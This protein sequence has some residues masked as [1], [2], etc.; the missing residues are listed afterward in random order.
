MSVH[1]VFG[2]PGSGK[3]LLGT[4]QMVLRDL[5]ETRKNVGTNFPIDIGK[6]NAYL[7]KRYPDRDFRVCDR[8]FLIDDDNLRDFFKYRGPANPDDTGVIYH[9]DEA[10]IPF[11]AL[12]WAKQNKSGEREV[13]HYLTQHRKMGDDVWAYTQSP[14]NLDK[15]FRS[16][17]QD[18]R[19][20][21][22]HRL[23]KLGVFRG[24]DKFKCH[25]FEFEASK[26]SEAYLVEEYHLDPNGGIASLYD[27]AKGIG[28]KGTAAD[29]GA[30]AKGLT[31]GWGVV[32]L[33]LLASLVF[34]IPW[35]MGKATQA[36]LGKPKPIEL[37][38][39]SKKTAFVDTSKKGTQD[40]DAG[41]R[42]ANSLKTN[43]TFTRSPG[44]MPWSDRD[45]V[46]V[47]GYVR[48]GNE[49]SVILTD[50]RTVTE[51]EFDEGDW[52]RRG[53][54]RLKGET[55]YFVT[56]EPRTPA[57][58]VQSAS[59]SDSPPENAPTLPEPPSGPES[60]WET[61]SDGVSRLK[62]SETLA[63]LIKR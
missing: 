11:N 52:I 32:G 22:N 62:Q 45:Q 54:V 36:Y 4:R 18:F 8:L 41:I 39:D 49:V 58:A 19:R 51:R 56:P 23:K 37:P 13:F 21:E 2:K 57:S 43:E 14:G 1:I 34:V 17:A 31:I 16:L 15:Q 35:G 5:V 46:R 63:D 7:Q 9:L 55:L 3:S 60:S 27:T 28:I 53:S 42:P 26:K 40:L 10:Q 44:Q 24:M 33:F 30:R 29:K 6:V 61:A 47:R 38:S 59:E 12:D 48:R 20:C 25:H 50:G